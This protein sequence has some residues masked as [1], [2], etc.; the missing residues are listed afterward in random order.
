MFH[1]FCLFYFNP[2]SFLFSNIQNIKIEKK[3]TKVKFIKIIEKP[4]PK[5]VP[6]AVAKPKRKRI[7][8]IKKKVKKK[9][10]KAKIKKKPV[11]PKN[12][13]KLSKKKKKVKKKIEKKIDLSSIQKKI[14]LMKK[15]E[16]RKEELRKKL[17]EEKKLKEKMKQEAA[18]FYSNKI[19][20]L[21]QSLWVFPKGI[22]DSEL[23]NLEIKVKLRVNK[24][25]KI[26]G[27]PQILTESKNKYFNESAL[28]AIEKLNNYKIPLPD[29]IDEQYLDIIIT[30][31]PPNL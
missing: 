18:V 5:P 4:K 16:K 27:K 22:D 15:Q 11:Q 6:K 9:I 19:V 26:I 23:S 8:K 30:L 13:L 12:K 24:N 25:G 7:I 20:S 10:E 2:K 3:V 31:V 14:E 17:E 29:I 21:I 28:R 1:I